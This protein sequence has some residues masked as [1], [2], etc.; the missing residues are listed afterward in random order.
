VIQNHQP[1]SVINRDPVIHNGQIF[2]N[3][4]GNIILN[5][6]LPVSD[7]SRGGVIHLDP[8]KRITQMICGMHEFMQSWGFAV[9]NPY[10][11]LTKKGGEFDIDQLPPGRYRVMVWH[12]HLKPVEKEVV[13]PANGRVELNF[14][15]DATKV[16]RPEYEIQK[17]FRVGPEAHPHEDLTGDKHKLFIQE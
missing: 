7:E 13:V 14:E 15:F 8:G 16:K 9:D 1:I 3:E 4:R 17:K 5:F 12:P 2:Q 10:Y 11:A 6:P